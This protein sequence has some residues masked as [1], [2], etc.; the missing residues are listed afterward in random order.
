MTKKLCRFLTLTSLLVIVVLTQTNAA[1]KTTLSIRPVQEPLLADLLLH[2]EDVTR[3]IKGFQP[4]TIETLKLYQLGQEGDCYS[5]THSLCSYQYFLVV[6]GGYGLP[7]AVYDL[8]NV[9][10]ISSIQATSGK[11]LRL[12]LTVLNYPSFVL[13]DRPDLK[14]EQVKKVI[15]VTL[16]S[17]KV[18]E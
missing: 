17:A 5:E 4:A 8:G 14:R 16:D 12:D 1:G 11:S 2:G 15:E 13:N 9:G 18:V 10:E 6:S 3:R 7:S